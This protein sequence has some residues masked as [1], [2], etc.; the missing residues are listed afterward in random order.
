MDASEGEPTLEELRRRYHPDDAVMLTA[1]AKQSME[2][3]LPFEFDIR[4]VKKDGT[5][6][7]MHSI[8]RAQLGECGKAERLVGTLMDIHERRMAEDALRDSDSR[9]RMVLE[10]GR[11]SIWRLDLA[12]NQFLGATARAKALFGLPEDA[13]FTRAE[14]LQAIHPGDR[15]CVQDA[16]QKTLK[17]P[18]FT[19]VEFR[20]V[21]PDGSVHWLSAHGSAVLDGDGQSIGVDGVIHEIT[22][23]KWIEFQREQALR[24]AEDRADRDPLTGLWNHRAFHKRLEEEAARREREGGALTVAMIDIDNFK[25]FN[26]VYGHVTGDDLLREV[27]ARLQSICRPYDIIS[28]FGGDEFALLLPGPD[29]ITRAEIE[30]RLRAGLQGLAYAPPGSGTPIPISLTL[31]VSIFP[32]QGSDRHEVVRLADERLRR[33]KTGEEVE[34]EAEQVRAAMTTTLEGFSMLDALVTAVDNKDRYTRRHSED[35]MAYCLTIARA[36]G[37]SQSERRTI[38]AAALLHDVG[39]IGVPDAVLRKPGALTDSEYEAVKHHP[40]MG[41]AI[42]STVAGLEATLDAVRHHHERWDGRGYPSGLRGTEIPFIARLMAVADA[43]SAMTTDRPYRIGMPPRKALSILESGAGSQ[44]DP[45]CVRAFVQSFSLGIEKRPGGVNAVPVFGL[46]YPAPLKRLPF[47]VP[48]RSGEW[49]MPS[50]A[51]QAGGPVLSPMEREGSRSSWRS[52]FSQSRSMAR[53][54][55][56]TMGWATLVRAG[57]V[58]R[59]GRTPSNPSTDSPRGIAIRRPAHHFS[60]AQAPGS[61]RVNM[62]VG[63]GARFQTL[64]IE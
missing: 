48:H 58:K 53:F 38:G 59:L 24:E 51:V 5:L 64:S 19:E 14:F 3:G 8:G 41:A 36:M 6:R 34:T 44:W 1:L 62:A 23:R 22:D 47:A 42:V 18:R 43:F 39:K 20:A 46:R 52:S 15:A 29:H 35:V 17:T 49:P 31:G 33:A 28:R 7:W 16:L 45:A 26:D 13:P 10:K 32:R 4:I 37:L 27:A 11:F 57:C 55:R 40:Q 9:L 25:F 56:S 30:H 2:D 12:S 61:D 60:T 63:R 21:W 54:A 50:R